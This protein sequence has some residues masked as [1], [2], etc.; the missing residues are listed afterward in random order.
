MRRLAIIL[1]ILLIFAPITNARRLAVVVAIS[2]YQDSGWN[3]INAS[4]DVDRIKESLK[5]FDSIRIISESQATYSNVVSALSGQN[6]CPSDTLCLFF[7]CHGQQVYNTETTEPLDESL[8]MYD[9]SRHNSQ[10]YAGECHLIDDFLAEIIDDWRHSA[11]T[12]GLVMVVS[13]ACHSGDLVRDSKKTTKIARGVSDVLGAENLSREIIDS[14]RKADRE[15][16]DLS[17]FAV[18]GASNVVYISACRSN[19]VNYEIQVDGNNCGALIFSTTMAYKNVGLRDISS[20][21]DCTISYMSEYQPLQ[22]PVVQTTFDYSPVTFDI[23][24]N[25]VPQQEQVA[26]DVRILILI[27]VIII[28]LIALGIV[29]YGNRHSR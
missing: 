5:D 10:S 18:P 2:D 11:G 22:T 27:G 12:D 3:H 15:K 20:F 6:V 8:V 1:F 26:L 23:N 4:N 9:A 16:G 17:V 19:E 28:L 7:S 13:D 25:L 21:L 24:D 29:I 14:L